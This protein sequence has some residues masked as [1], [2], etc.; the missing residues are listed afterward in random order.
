MGH[1]AN[2]RVDKGRK[3]EVQWKGLCLTRCLDETKRIVDT[4]L[5][6]PSDEQKSW[7]MCG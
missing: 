5:D 7:K 1:A 3:R 2:T 4:V 6:A